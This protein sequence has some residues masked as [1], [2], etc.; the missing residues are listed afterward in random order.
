MAAE[1]ILAEFLQ[2]R[3]GQVTPEIPVESPQ[4]RFELLQPVSEIPLG[5][6]EQPDTPEN[7]LQEFLQRKATTEQIVEQP[8]EEKGFFNRLKDLFTGEDRATPET[9]G[10]PELTAQLMGLGQRPS[11]KEFILAGRMLL[12]ATDEEKRKLIEETVPDAAFRTDEK[13][14][15][16]VTL[17][18]REEAVLN[19]PGFSLDDALNITG[20]IALFTPAGRVAKGLAFGAKTL[21]RGGV[22][23]ATETGR[24]VA[25]EKDL[26]PVEIGLAG[27]TGVVGEV[28]APLLKGGGRLLRKGAARIPGL[29]RVQ[30]PGEALGVTAEEGV[31]GIEAVRAADILTE[32]TGIPLFQAQKTL[33][34]SKLETQ[35]FVASLPGG[36]RKAAQELRIQ[37]KSAFDAVQTVMDTLAPP[38]S[39]VTA[40]GRVRSAAEAAIKAKEAIRKEFADP[41][42]DEA[43]KDLS[44]IALPKTRTLINTIKGELPPKEQTLITRVEDLL[45]PSGVKEKKFDPLIAPGRVVAKGFPTTKLHRAKV[46]I[47]DMISKRGEGSLG[48][49][50][51]RELIEIQKEFLDELDI[52]NPAYKRA[53]KVFSDNSPAVDELKD[54]ILG[55]ITE[56]DDTQ[57]K[58]VTTKLFDPTETN[59]TII[60]KAKKVIES[61]DPQA[62]RDITRLEFERRLGTIRAVAPGQTTENVPGQLHRALFGNT[63]QRKVLFAG[64][65]DETA[66]NVRYLEEGLRRASLGRPGGSPTA[67]REEIKKELRSGF[68]NAIRTFIKTP[69]S[70]LA[71]AG[72]TVLAGE[73]QD[74]AFTNATRSL[75]NVMYDPKWQVPLA[76]LRKLNPRSEQAGK[77]FLKILNEAQTLG[78]PA[79]QAV[80]PQIEPVRRIPS[81]RK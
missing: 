48:R 18:G 6:V 58:T 55:K 57:L 19:R 51:K 24:Q 3:G 78:K 13:G 22:A 20:M 32:Q 11:I 46:V 30:A 71:G 25:I 56:L 17:P 37:N 10:A 12:T 27:A 76:K 31:E 26:D 81:E 66:K 53:R 68:L 15:T 7:I 60:K 52:A 79:L 74:A 75:A 67:T 70:S 35:S 28:A 43:K 49:T 21:I 72:V 62:W 5:M 63:K 16:F 65:D 39:I 61:Q 29:R 77:L 23:A 45:F 41:I 42:Y 80:R 34:P 1:D 8:P 47:D 59:V 73:A 9:E 33:V 54:S 44:R 50:E 69:V 4:D 36:S 40:T 2:R 14:N 38:E 64:L